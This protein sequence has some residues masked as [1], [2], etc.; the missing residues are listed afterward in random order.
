MIRKFLFLINPRA[1]L[2]QNLRLEELIAAACTQ[3]GY[4]YE[5]MQTPADSNY[6]SVAAHI[7]NSNSTDII[8]CGGDGT[9]STVVSSL[10][11]LPVQFGIIPRGSGNG[12]AFAAGIPK[13]PR[14]A[15]ELIFRNNAQP[16]DAFFINGTFS[17]ML[18]GLGF[19][20]AV[21]HAFD[22]QTKRGLWKYVQLTLQQLKQ[23]RSYPFVLETNGQR[24]ETNALFL[25][26]A[27]SNQFGNHFTI[28]PRASLQDGLLDLVAVEQAGK[29]LLLLRLLWH[30]R[31]GTFTRN[32]QHRHGIL[33]LQTKQVRILNPHRAPLHIDGDGKPTATTFDIEIIPAAYRLL[34]P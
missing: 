5:L 30:L 4:L 21:A 18:S 15:L 27:N 8:I 6:H 16:V 23:L 24:I 29:L 32:L 9:I 26:I 22:R 28:A 34:L 10:R 12:L 20:A 33:Y 3:H 14:K 2:Q 7:S 17:C 1:G 13:S 31:F 25:S 19:D 11:H